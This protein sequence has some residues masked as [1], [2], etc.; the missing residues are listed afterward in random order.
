MHEALALPS[1]RFSLLCK[2]SCEFGEDPPLNRASSGRVPGV[3]SG[4]ERTV[5]VRGLSKHPKLCQFAIIKPQD[6]SEWFAVVVR[7]PDVWS[8]Y[9]AWLPALFLAPKTV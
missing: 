4:P 5:R 8:V 1:A 7:Q 2:K 6:S 3:P 9:Q